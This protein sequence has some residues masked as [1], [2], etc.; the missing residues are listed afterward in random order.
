M[1]L[2]TVGVQPTLSGKVAVVSGSSTGIGAAVARELARR[3]AS[4]VVNYPDPDDKENADKVLSSLPLSSKSMAV[5][6]DLSTIEGARML[7]DA[8]AENFGKVDILV[9]N[10][11]IM[12]PTDVDDPDDS[13]IEESWEKLVNL[14]ARGTY[15]LTRAVLKIL[16]PKNSRIVNIGSGSSRVASTGVS[17]YAGT[18]GMI[19]SWTR[20]WA[21]ELPRKYGCTVN[22]V[23]P[24]YVATES[25]K[26]APESVK[27]PIKPLIE[28]TPV[29]PREATTEEVAWTVA[30]LCEEPAGWINGAYLPVSGGT[31]MI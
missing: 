14:N 11:G 25:Y 10:A 24:G 4:V 30:M 13:R 12:I 29:A 1:S 21:K 28:Q 8:A 26:A 22:A 18:K 19:E 5:E 3:G 6:A 17:I 27:E 20:C 16:A 7:A 2:S 31:V 23:V 15:F 9:N